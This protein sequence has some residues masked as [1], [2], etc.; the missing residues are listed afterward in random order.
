MS[1]P[2]SADIN[3]CYNPE[4]CHRSCDASPDPLR[5]S[6]SMPWSESAD[7]KVTRAYMKVVAADSHDKQCA[8]QVALELDAVI[9]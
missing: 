6:N 1:L 9:Q 2:G 8:Q 4:R 7:L 3:Q 5:L